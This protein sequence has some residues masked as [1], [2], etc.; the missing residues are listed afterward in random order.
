MTGIERKLTTILA[1]DVVGFSKMMGSN[2]TGTL[3][4]LKAC[5]AIIDSG[6]AEHHGRIFGSAGD[7]VV[8]EFS[9]P[10][11]AVLCANEFQKLLAE[12]NAHHATK[13]RM[14]FRVGVNMG[15]VIIDGDNL[16]GEG[17]NVAARLEAIAGP[18]GVCLSG[19]VYEE[20]KRKLDLSFVAGGAQ[21][22]K[23]IID[24]VPVYHL[25]GR[26]GRAADGGAAV[27]A[28]GQAVAARARQADAPPTVAVLPLK[29][30]SGDGEVQSLVEGLHED[31]LGGLAKLTAIA[32]LG[33]DGGPASGS[34]GG[35]DFRLEG[36]ARAAGRRLRL[37]FTLFDA[38]SQSQAWSERYDRQLDDIF[39]LEDEIS[40]NVVSAVR[41]RLKTRAFEQL[42]GKENA[43]L[44]VPDLLS[45]AAGFFVH[46]YGRNQ[47]VVEILRLAMDRQPDSSMAV[48]M[49]GFCRHRM[50]EFSIL[51]PS[52]DVK[53]ELLGYPEKAISLDPSSYFAHLMAAVMHQDLRGDY[54][55]A[56]SHAETSLEINSSFGLAR[57]M[58]GICKCHLGEIDQGIEMVQ[59]TTAASPEDPHRF[60]HLRE[61]AIAHFMTGQDEQAVQVANRL[62]HQAP[63][64]SRNQL[65]LASLSWQAGREDAARDCVAGL[66]RDQP[67]L[68]LRTM[69]PVRF[70]DPGMA[71]RYARGLRDAGL[72]E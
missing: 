67:E 63:E 14:Q 19:K 15:D 17:V 29:V 50:L 35:A 61:L 30:I 64:L 34:D 25:S 42:R 66:L 69:R 4:S 38:A 40:E 21:K 62:V 33:A 28:A 26:G 60:R 12:R 24:P 37:S 48:G 18:G 9:S 1:A 10:V 8:A 31:I 58:V 44:S 5:R 68:T 13:E 71:E 20:V 52:E 56:L 36:S 41:F 51:D 11:Q 27:L 6:I 65:V 53:E 23:G 3:E 46:A 22:L 70:A 43:A 32:V 59:R 7:S 54:E 72:P 2:E 39:D 45:K 16:Y 55:T 49:M 57:A 47:E